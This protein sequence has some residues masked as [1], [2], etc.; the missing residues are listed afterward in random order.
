MGPADLV[1]RAIQWLSGEE[2]AALVD[3]SYNDPK[4]QAWSTRAVSLAGRAALSRACVRNAWSNL[5]SPPIEMPGALFGSP[6]YAYAGL[7]KGLANRAALLC[8]FSWGEL[9]SS[10]QRLC[11]AFFI[12]CTCASPLPQLRS[13]RPPHYRWR[14]LI[15]A[16][17]GALA[18]SIGYSLHS[19][20]DATRR[21][22]ELRCR[23]SILI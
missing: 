19:V 17:L 22:V 6:A 9:E 2:G 23:L 4:L 7:V 14:C 15:K 3:L 5:P 10:A 13:T 16:I 12:S 20:L 21:Q 8:G 1:A 11:L 18:R